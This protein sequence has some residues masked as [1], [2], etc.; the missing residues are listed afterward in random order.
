LTLGRLI[1]RDLARNP[2]RLGLTILAA[3]VGVLAFVF[4]QSIIDLWYAGVA[5]SQ[6]DRLV[7]RNKTSFT[8]PLPLA[9]LGRI[10]AVPGVA[11]VTY[12]G[13]F[14]GI[15][16]ESRKDFFP[17]FFVDPTSYLQ[18]YYDYSVPQAEL[19]AFRADPCGALIGEALAKRFGWETGERVTLKGT[20][21][22]GT[23]TFTIRGTYRPASPSADTTAL[24]FPYRCLNERLPEGQRD[25]VGYFAVRV[26]D[27]ARSSQVSAAIDAVFASSPYPTQTESERA[28]QLGFVAMSSAILAA[29]RIVSYVILLII[30]LVVGNTLAMEVRERVVELSTLRAIGFR[31]SHVALIVLAESAVIG[32]GAAALGIPAAP[33]LVRGFFHVVSR[34]FGALPKPVIDPGSLAAGAAL[35]LLIALAGGALPALRATRLPVAEGLRRVA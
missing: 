18:V 2:L 31:S 9:D 24:V 1:R 26:D 33:Y 29:V 16:S 8:Q 35:S 14:G 4:L 5:V 19:T 17:N 21:F 32:V 7:V 30:L 34:Q 10:K 15:R 28:F 12:A 13:W 11:A 3:A 25:M 20:I 23:W 27:P 22:P 6:P